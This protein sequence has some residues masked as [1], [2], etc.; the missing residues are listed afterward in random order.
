MTTLY[1][2]AM[3]K[4]KVDLLK[5]YQLF[6]LSFTLKKVLSITFSFLE[7]RNLVMKPLNNKPALYRMPIIIR[8]CK[9]H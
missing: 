6:L 1:Y 2:L 4:L 3:F 8:I 5:T 9:F 7:I